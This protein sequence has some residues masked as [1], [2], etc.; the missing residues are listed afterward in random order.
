MNTHTLKTILL[1]SLFV[2]TAA[3][4]SSSSDDSYYYIDSGLATGGFDKYQ[5]DPASTT[6]SGLVATF[7]DSKVQFL[8]EASTINSSGY[9]SS[10]SFSY[11]DDE[12]SAVSCPGMSIK[13]GHTTL[14]ALTNTFA[15]NVELGAGSLETVKTSATVRFPAGVIGDQ[16]AIK[17]DTPFYYNG[18]NN[19]VVQIER[20]DACDGIFNDMVTY[21]T[22]VSAVWSTIS[23]ATGATGTWHVNLDFHFAG[24]DNLVLA[25][26]DGGDNGNSIAP[27]YTGRTQSLVRQEDIDGKGPITGI[28][29]ETNGALAGDAEATYT[30]TLS[31]VDATTDSLISTFADNVGANAKVVA[32]DVSVTV[33]AGTNWFWIPLTGNFKYD[34]T[35]NLLIDIKA[36]VTSGSFSMDYHN[37]GSNRIVSSNDPLSATGIVR[38]RTYQP[39]LRFN[40]GKMVVINP[41]GGSTTSFL[42]TSDGQYA[43]KYTATQL[44]TKGRISKLT[45]RIQNNVLTNSDFPDTKIVLGHASATALTSTYADNMV[46]ATTVYNGTHT[47]TAGALQGDWTEFKFSRSFNYNGVDDLIV[48]IF[49]GIGTATVKCTNGTGTDSVIYSPDPSAAT[50][51]AVGNYLMDVGL[52]IKP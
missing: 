4:G 5:G 37:A 17:L 34:G 1:G 6:Y 26:D 27:G 12:V 50:G 31:H 24:G 15:N 48:H 30:V 39:K 42:S 45:C 28:A 14:T 18:I 7:P 20:V 36:T 47:I 11:E 21:V 46:N 51:G 49:G 3:C 38:S 10:I 19:L 2:L 16:H 23:A 9:I 8:Y 44:G 22:P 25:Q 35:S 41:A 13:M 29:L 40:G 43:F 33:P 32:E 52:S